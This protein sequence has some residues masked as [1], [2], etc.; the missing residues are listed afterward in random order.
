MLENFIVE[1]P[2]YIA[3]TFNMVLIL[4]L[5][6][7]FVG[8]IIFVLWF[9]KF[10]KKIIIRKVING[11]VIIKEDKARLYK[12]KLGVKWWQLW[13]EKDK[14]LKN[15]E[16]PPA[17]AIEINSKGKEFIEVYLTESGHY[18]FI[19]DMVR[20]A[21]I[22]PNI[23]DKVPQEVTEEE[24]VI[25]RESKLEEWK[26]NKIDSWKE[27]I[28]VVEAFLP[29][30]SQ[31]RVLL[32]NNIA[33]AEKRKGKNFME[34]LPAMVAIG[35]AV[36]LAVCLMVFWADIAAPVLEARQMGIQE[37]QIQTENL[38]LIKEINNNIQTIGSNNQEI[39]K[40]LTE[41]EKEK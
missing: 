7:A 18:V 39:N 14:S 4:L 40:R 38:N 33:A 22:P 34:N 16:L 37:A 26:K 10:N 8:V 31:Q 27:S 1:L 29:F 17:D 32:V 3:K 2:N 21:E 6:L 23:F 11:R 19:K 41:I 35:G 20:V 28:G 13:N 30:T 12:D 15:L 5:V 25:L 24:N 9:M 36:I